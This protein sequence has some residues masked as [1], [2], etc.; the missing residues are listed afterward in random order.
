M[1]IYLN[2]NFSGGETLFNFLNIKIKPEKGSVLFFD[3]KYIDDLNIKTS[4]EGLSV[5]EGTKY[6]INYWIRHKPYIL[7]GT[8]LD[9]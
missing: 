5:I 3:Y 8:E 6:I 2:D 9:K 7:E 1:I 4:H